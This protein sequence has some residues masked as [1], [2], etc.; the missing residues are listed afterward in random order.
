MSLLPIGKDTIRYGSADGGVTVHDDDP[1]LS[2]QLKTFAKGYHLKKHIVGKDVG[3]RALYLPGDIEGHRGHDDRYYLLDF[4]RLMPPEAPSN[5]YVVTTLLGSSPVV[6]C[7]TA[8]SCQRINVHVFVLSVP[9]TAKSTNGPYSTEP[10]ERSSSNSTAT[11]HCVVMPSHSLIRL[12]EQYVS[13][14]E[15]LYLYLHTHTHT[16]IHID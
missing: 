16:H 6:W 9:S 12:L 14:N 4:A 1:F 5:E 7:C 13:D 11:N 2:K 15:Y 10:S 8:H 3:A